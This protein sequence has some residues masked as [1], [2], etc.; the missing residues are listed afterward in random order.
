MR[1]QVHGMMD[2]LSQAEQSMLFAETQWTAMEAHMAAITGAMAD[3]DFRRHEA[4]ALL[5]TVAAAAA[6]AVLAVSHEIASDGLEWGAEVAARELA[7][8][9]WALREDWANMFAALAS[10]R[11]EAWAVSAGLG[12]LE[13]GV[14]GLCRSVLATIK[15]AA[16]ARGLDGARRQHGGVVEPKSLEAGC[17]TATQPDRWQVCG[18]CLRMLDRLGG[19]CHI[20][21]GAAAERV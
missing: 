12:A 3:Q 5:E 13:A 17:Q 1:A 8:E 14:E 11:E 7:S 4:L 10:R 20:L 9:N 21:S 16:A 2:Q 19:G 18:C 6:D 15:E